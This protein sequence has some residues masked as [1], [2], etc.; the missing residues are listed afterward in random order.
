MKT[1]RLL[2]AA[3][4]EMLDAA[5]YYEEQADGLGNVFLD[6]INSA[7]KDISH[8]PETWPVIRAGIRR[9]LLHRFPF[10]L[11]YRVDSDEVVV[12]A[13]MHLRRHPNYWIDR[14]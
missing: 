8:N 7:Q 6:K 2:E 10:A 13:V 12:L 1:V 4:D 9:R 14:L 3:E 11:L 5:R